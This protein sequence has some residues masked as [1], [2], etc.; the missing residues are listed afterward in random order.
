[1]EKIIDIDGRKIKFKATAGLPVRYRN[2]FGTEYLSDLQK[3]GLTAKK[4]QG[5]AVKSKENSTENITEE[6]INALSD[7][8]ISV[9]YQIA[10]TMAKTADNSIPPLLDW[11]DTFDNFPIA[12]IISEL[13][14]LMNTNN[15]T[16]TKN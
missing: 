8:D 16:L 7:I 4:L 10:W 12:I 14:E 5:V 9:F 6:E 15:K 1:M 11:L 13:S 2:A 3:A